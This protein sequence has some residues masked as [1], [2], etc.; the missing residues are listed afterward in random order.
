MKITCDSCGSKYSISDAKVKGRKVKVRCKGCKASILVD[1]TALDDAS[2]VADQ[3][4]ALAAAGPATEQAAAEVWSVNLSEDD[5]REMSLEQLVEA[6]QTGVVTAEAYVWK[7]GMADWKPILEVG[8]LKLQLAAASPPGT[9][10]QAAT[11]AAFPAAAPA[12]VAASPLAATPA[13]QAGGMDDL[14]GGVDLAGS[15]AA[16]PEKPGF[17]SA[18]LDA[19][20]TGARNDSSV[21]FS[22]DS[23]K[24]AGQSQQGPSG[25][26]ADI[27][28]NLGSASTGTLTTNSDLL[29]APA[30]DPPKPVVAAR[31]TTTA[32]GPRKSLVVPIVLSILGAAAVAAGAFFFLGGSDSAEAE[33]ELAAASEAK[34]KAAE[35]RKKAE[36]EKAAL[37][38][39][40]KK[41]EEALKSAEATKTEEKPGQDNEK[42]EEETE[43]PTDEG[44]TS[45]SSTSKPTSK[46]APAS[47][48]PSTS[49]K[50]PPFNVSAAKS[51]LSTAAANAAG[52]KKSGGPTGKG[53][54]QITFSTSGRV[55]SASIISG[56]FGGTSTGGCVASTFRRARVPAFSGS[57]QTVAKSFTIR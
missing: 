54:V 7:D 23:L 40:L 57:A 49:S 18:G 16:E 2:A 53:K 42:K 46:P 43:E 3:G 8:E 31:A 55:T 19:K 9:A 21:L 13:A 47:K 35:E 24:S 14:F 11:P 26:A 48:K 50:K 10:A 52:C 30:K 39:K 22:L 20:P 44:K 5:S 25:Q 4:A 36:A 56:P 32:P 17:P 38:E 15:Q 51:A 34:E 27:F 41:M 37:A 28:G 1:G 45:A 33:A 29:T 12:A 6:W